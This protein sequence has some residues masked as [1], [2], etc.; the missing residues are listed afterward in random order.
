MDRFHSQLNKA[1]DVIEPHT[2]CDY[3]RFVF[4]QNNFGAANMRKNK[5]SSNTRLLCNL[6]CISGRSRAESSI[7]LSFKVSVADRKLLFL[8][9]WLSWIDEQ[10][11]IKKLKM[12]FHS[13]PTSNF[14]SKKSEKASLIA[15]SITWTVLLT[16]LSFFNEKLKHYSERL[17]WKRTTT[18]MTTC[19]FGSL[20]TSNFSQ[21]FIKLRQFS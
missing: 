9:F 13:R 21:N 5:S 17:W 2:S 10:F 8:Y 1:S 6:F 11:Y 3:F 20:T 16:F 18:T 12:N 14:P 15:S 19:D 4:W 7:F